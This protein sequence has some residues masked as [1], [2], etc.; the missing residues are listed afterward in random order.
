MPITTQ[1]SYEFKDIHEV[2]RQSGILHRLPTK[3]IKTDSESLSK[4]A[5]GVVK[6][7]PSK[8]RV[9]LF[10]SKSMQNALMDREE[11]LKKLNLEYAARGRKGV[12]K[13]LIL[14]WTL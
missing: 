13:F 7:N 9:S 14:I 5:M 12:V 4:E 10:T 8:K 2:R 3:E 6:E 11:T 1:K